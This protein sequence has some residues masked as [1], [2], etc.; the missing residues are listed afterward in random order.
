MRLD[1]KALTSE[2]DAPLEAVEAEATGQAEADDDLVTDG[3]AAVAVFLGLELAPQGLAAVG[4]TAVA[5]GAEPAA[6]GFVRD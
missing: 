5:Q 1:G 3:E 2:T 4:G 6:Q